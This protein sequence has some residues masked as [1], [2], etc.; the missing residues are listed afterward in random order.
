MD[1]W[2]GVLIA[3]V[4]LLCTL[5]GW[6]VSRVAAQNT[7]IDTQRDTIDELKRQVD[8]MSMIGEVTEKVLAN[9]PLSRPSGGGKR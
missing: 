6:L 8:R 5:C 4:T 9:L 7:I 2:I 1:P 3:V